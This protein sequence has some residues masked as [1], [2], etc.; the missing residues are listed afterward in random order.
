M[1][2]PVRLSAEA[3]AEYDDAGDW[4]ERR[5]PGKGAVFTQAVQDV[6]DLVSAH[7]RM[8]AVVFKD[9]RKAVVTGFPYVVYYREEAG[10]LVVISVF[11]TSRD[12]ADWQSRV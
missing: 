1:S 6:L 3:E 5:H 10:G 4:Y 8:H 2:L 7:P 11:H 9:V 12:P